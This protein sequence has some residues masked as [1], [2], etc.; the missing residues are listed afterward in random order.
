MAGAGTGD[1]SARKPLERPQ[2]L[3]IHGGDGD[4]LL[5]AGDL[6]LAEQ[7]AIVLWTYACPCARPCMQCLAP[8]FIV[9]GEGDKGSQQGSSSREDG[10]P[11][12]QCDSSTCE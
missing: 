10:G 9:R 4:R 1:G 8:V 3:C 2:A 12:D 5:L 6:G 11:L 7:P